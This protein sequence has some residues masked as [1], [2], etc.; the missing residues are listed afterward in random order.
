MENFSNNKYILTKTRRSNAYTKLNK[1]KYVK[2]LSLLV[3]NGNPAIRANSYFSLVI[4]ELSSI[5]WKFYSSIITNN[6]GLIPSNHH[7]S[8]LFQSLSPKLYKSNTE[9]TVSY[10]YNLEVLQFSLHKNTFSKI[11][12]FYL[13]TISS[14]SAAS[15]LNFN[16][17]TSFIWVNWYLRFNPMNNVFYLKIYNY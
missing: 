13:C 4:S 2:L 12:M 8:I 7:K 3:L 16:V 14:A 6:T 9:L 17:K 11:L 15:G 1:I 10:Y 5:H